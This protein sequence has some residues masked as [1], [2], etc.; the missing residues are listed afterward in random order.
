MTQTMEGNGYL[1][2]ADRLIARVRYQ[3]RWGQDE[4]GRSRVEGELRLPAGRSPAGGE[5]RFLMH[6]EAGFSLPVTAD[7][8]RATDW[9]P[10]RR[11]APEEGFGDLG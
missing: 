1:F 5:T 9:I 2:H 7:L 8:S 10:F 6:T 3:L 4:A 11:V